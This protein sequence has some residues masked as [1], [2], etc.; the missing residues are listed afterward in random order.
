MNSAIRGYRVRA[1]VLACLERRGAG[2]FCVLRGLGR[3]RI[4]KKGV[5]GLGE[6]GDDDRLGCGGV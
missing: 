6:Q 1:R 5:N 4:S 2:G 3:R